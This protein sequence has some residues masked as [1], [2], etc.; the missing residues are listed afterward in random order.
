[1]SANCSYGTPEGILCG[2]SAKDPCGLSESGFPANSSQ[3]R[4]VDGPQW[5]WLGVQLRVC[6]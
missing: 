4:A 5:V 3:Q 2:T 6:P 1:M